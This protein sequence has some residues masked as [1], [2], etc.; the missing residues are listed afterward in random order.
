MRLRKIILK[1]HFLFVNQVVR[2]TVLDEQRL[3]STYINRAT[4]RVLINNLANNSGD[5]LG[6]TRQFNEMFTVTFCELTMCDN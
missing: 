3:M 6:F 4:I 5:P 2:G 1:E